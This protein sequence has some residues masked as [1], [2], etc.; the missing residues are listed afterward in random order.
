MRLA[1]GYMRSDA[2]KERRN[3]AQRPADTRRVLMASTRSRSRAALELGEGSP[4]AGIA[5]ESR[6]DD[7]SG[8]TS[9]RSDGTPAARD[10][11]GTLPAFQPVG[12]RG[13]CS[14]RLNSLE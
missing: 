12:E 5:R 13:G 4:H 14:L 7:R 6:V 8:H 10:R 9:K 2:A 3:Y 1:C 11:D